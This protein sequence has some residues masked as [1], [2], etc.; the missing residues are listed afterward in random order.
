MAAAIAI[1]AWLAGWLWPG[2][3]VG[4]GEPPP[5]DGLALGPERRTTSLVSRSQS[6]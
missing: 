3:G 5:E 6:R 1:G 2:V 4:F